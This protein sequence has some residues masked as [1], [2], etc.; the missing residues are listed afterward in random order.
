[1][2]VKVI[3][4]GPER[5]I[6]VV[7]EAGEEV[8]DCLQRVAE[9]HRLSAAAFTGLGAFERCVLG[10]FRWET[11]DYRRIEIAEQVEVLALIGNI[12]LE[13]GEPKLH[14]HVTLGKADGT[15]HGG[16]LL[17]AHVRPVLEI[18]VTESPADLR[19]EHDPRSGL[20]LLSP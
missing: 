8:L 7:L 10:F 17:E 13:D 4:E 16:H 18:V 5:T 19:R 9:E 20:A 15:A 2:Q 12:A 1:M 6:A 3:R 14:P 11:K